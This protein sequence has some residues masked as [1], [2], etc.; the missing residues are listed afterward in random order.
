MVP[1]TAH[2]GVISGLRG[3]WPSGNVAVYTQFLLLPEFLRHQG[4]SHIPLNSVALE[5]AVALGSTV[6]VSEASNEVDEAGGVAVVFPLSIGD[7]LS[8]LDAEAL[9][10]SL[11][12]AS[13]APTVTR[14]ARRNKQRRG[15]PLERRR[16]LIAAG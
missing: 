15:H 11:F 4:R 6:W 14:A 7:G 16:S 5:S 9:D 12:P 8:V 1:A 2:P 10:A 13:S 3:S